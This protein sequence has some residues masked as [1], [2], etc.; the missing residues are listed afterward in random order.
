LASLM[1]IDEDAKVQAKADALQKIATSNESEYRKHL[2]CEC[3]EA[4]PLGGCANERV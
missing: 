1:R 2:L 3:V 4:Y